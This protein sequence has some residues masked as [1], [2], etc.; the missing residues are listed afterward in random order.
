MHN[1][2][3]TVKNDKGQKSFPTKAEALAFANAVNVFVP[4]PLVRVF[5]SI[6]TEYNLDGSPAIAKHKPAVAN[7]RQSRFHKLYQRARE[8]GCLLE[9]TGNHYDLNNGRGVC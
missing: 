4:H 2:P 3:Y 7:P 5:D 6:G 1:P 8:Q 9:K